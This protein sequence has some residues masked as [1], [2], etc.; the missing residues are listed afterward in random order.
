M[1][2]F[3]LLFVN[4]LAAIVWIVFAALAGY[5]TFDFL[6]Q[7]LDRRLGGVPLPGFWSASSSAR[8]RFPAPRDR[9]RLRAF[10]FGFAATLIAFV[11]LSGA[12][13]QWEHRHHWEGHIGIAVSLVGGLAFAFFRR[14][15]HTLAVG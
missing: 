13:G 15:R 5:A 4:P 2:F 12:L 11:V 9:P 1:A 6:G 8:S 14:P 10:T 3:A 7:A